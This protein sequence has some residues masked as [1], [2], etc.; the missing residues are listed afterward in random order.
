MILLTL[1]GK[2]AVF[3]EFSYTPIFLKIHEIYLWLEESFTTY[4][5]DVYL[6]YETARR[7]SLNHGKLLK[8]EDVYE[9]IRFIANNPKIG[10]KVYLVSP[11]R[12]TTYTKMPDSYTSAILSAQRYTCLILNSC[13]R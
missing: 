6:I 9:G 11:S 7:D 1:W 5:N 13:H 4:T 3:H 2:R 12:S 8:T 10:F